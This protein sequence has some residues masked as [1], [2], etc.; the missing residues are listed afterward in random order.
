ML[1]SKLFDYYTPQTTYCALPTMLT[2]CLRDQL[3][4]NCFCLLS[5]AAAC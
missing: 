1:S 2:C 5:Y 4:G 3:T